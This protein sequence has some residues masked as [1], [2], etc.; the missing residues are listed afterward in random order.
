MNG[1][2]A[3]LETSRHVSNIQNQAFKPS[4]RPPPVTD[5]SS[6]PSQKVP[7]DAF[8]LG[9]PTSDERTQPLFKSVMLHPLVRVCFY[10]R[11]KRAGCCK[12]QGEV[13]SDV[14]SLQW[15]DQEDKCPAA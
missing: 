7:N 13:V 1:T 8:V 9:I 14:P 6:W 11:V 3:N 10:W 12:S 2:L 5:G 4:A 15:N